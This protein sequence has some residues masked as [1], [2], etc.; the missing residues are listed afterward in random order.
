M[1][2]QDEIR[3]IRNLRPVPENRTEYDIAVDA[4]AKV[5]EFIIS[6]AKKH[7]EFQ[8]E[9]FSCCVYVIGACPNQMSNDFLIC[10]RGYKDRFLFGKSKYQTHW[11]YTITQKAENVRKELDAILAKDGLYVGE[12]QLVQGKDSD[13]EVP[14]EHTKEFGLIIRPKKCG[15][16]TL[17]PNQTFSLD[18]SYFNMNIIQPIEAQISYPK[19]AI[20]IY[21]SENEK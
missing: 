6:C 5:K 21:F 10:E 11:D 15:T 9:P 13:D 18:G 19:V 16:L 8:T 2:F 12:W 20:E 14:F 3:R 1:S 4:A 17:K 7:Y